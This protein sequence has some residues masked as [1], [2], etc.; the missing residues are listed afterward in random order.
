MEKDISASTTPA[1]R[2]ALF[3]PNKPITVDE[4]TLNKSQH[5]LGSF[6]VTSR[7]ECGLR[8]SWSVPRCTAFRYTATSGACLTVPSYQDLLPVGFEA[9]YDSEDY[10][11]CDLS[12]GFKIYRQS[13]VMACLSCHAKK[14]THAEANEE[15]R[16]TGGSIS[17]A[18]VN[19]HEK[20]QLVLDVAENSK[21]HIWVSE[22]SQLPLVLTR[23]THLVPVVRPT[24][25]SSTPSRCPAVRRKKQD[26]IYFPCNVAF[27]FC[28]EM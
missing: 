7:I 22:K 15:C 2:T 21:L 17:L 14:L 23:P 9:V 28:C 24:P 10:V 20:L 13:D 26:V 12:Q 25:K 1:T 6:T 8:C 19:S 11:A 5:Y 3:T 4:A 18:T 16:N 27:I